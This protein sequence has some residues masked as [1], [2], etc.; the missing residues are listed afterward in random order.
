[1]AVI[2]ASNDRAKFGNKALRAFSRRGFDVI[3]INPHAS[4]VEGFPAYASVLDVPRP[5]DM[6]TLY[7]PSD[8]G[9]RVVDEIAKKGIRELW[10]NPG[11]GSARLIARARDL[12]LEPVQHCSIV[13]I[14][15]SPWDY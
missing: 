2:G 6:A 4:D 14:G 15:E 11:A 5:I 13:A 7:V 1:M 9:E 8:I 12:G 3:P 10:V